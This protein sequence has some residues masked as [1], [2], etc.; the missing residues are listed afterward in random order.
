MSTESTVIRV[1]WI[2]SA[3]RQLTQLYL[4]W[5]MLSELLT[6]A[7]KS[8]STTLAS[9]L[10][11]GIRVDPT[12]KCRSLSGLG[13]FTLFAAFILLDLNLIASP[14]V[15]KRWG[16]MMEG[17]EVSLLPLPVARHCG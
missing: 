4:G 2:G 13:Q 17:S 9:D 16:S 15:Q 14:R 3:A 5:L 10:V 8:K 6:V 7:L 11:L 1:L 12:C